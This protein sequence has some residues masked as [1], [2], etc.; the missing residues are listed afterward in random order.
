MVYYLQFQLRGKSRFSRFPLKK[1]YN[2]NYR[3]EINCVKSV[4]VKMAKRLN[5]SL[6]H[7]KNTGADV[8][9]NF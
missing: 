1:F 6:F 3:C 2:I 5:M 8:I 7:P 9:N 4:T